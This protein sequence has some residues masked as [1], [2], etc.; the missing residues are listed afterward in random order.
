MTIFLRKTNRK[1]LEAYGWKCCHQDPS[2]MI[3]EKSISGIGATVILHDDGCADVRIGF[4]F[5]SR[6]I[7]PADLIGIGNEIKKLEIN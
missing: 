1:R 3:F 2:D 5:T 6:I 4:D 7:L